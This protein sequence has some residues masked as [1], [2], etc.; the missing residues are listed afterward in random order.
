[1]SEKPLAKLVRLLGGA[2]LSYGPLGHQVLGQLLTLN[3]REVEIAA[4]A[5][6][7]AAGSRQKDAVAYSTLRVLAPA[8]AVH[9]LT[10]REESRI[11]GIWSQL[12]A[13]EASLSQREAALAEIARPGADTPRARSAARAR[14]PRGGA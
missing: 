7:I 9:L 14:R 2:A 4:A 10:R 3:N 13:K 1:M 11:A 6:L 12:Q 5:T 8:I